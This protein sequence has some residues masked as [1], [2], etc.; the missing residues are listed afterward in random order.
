MRKET[1]RSEAL[2]GEAR[3]SLS[4]PLVL[5]R[6]SR[7]L[8]PLQRPDGTPTAWVFPEYNPSL[9]AAMSRNWDYM[10]PEYAIDEKLEPANDMYSLG[11][12][13]YAVHNKGAPPFRNRNS[14]TT[15]R[16]NADEL[17]TIIGSSSWARMGR[18]VLGEIA[19]SC[20]KRSASTDLCWCP[21]LL[22]T[23]LTRYP[24]SRLSAKA[25]QN[26]SYFNNILVSTLK[27]MER[28]NFA[29]RQ[30]EERVQFLKGLLTIL[31]QFSDRLL[32]RKVLPAVSK[33]ACTIVMT[34]EEGSPLILHASQILELMSD[35]SLL[36]FILPNVFYISKTL[37]EYGHLLPVLG[38][39]RLNILL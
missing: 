8:T 31:S 6:F 29:G 25:F 11:C 26:S 10:A 35:R 39:G 12:V 5:T 23:L 2:H 9:P 20:D 19:P 37:C 24:G 18:D 16:Q 22:G 36:P 14:V 1:G 15:L 3:A 30:K 7:S 38:S 27:F 4:L 32:R 28:D 13:V 34:R 33:E 17:S 21:D